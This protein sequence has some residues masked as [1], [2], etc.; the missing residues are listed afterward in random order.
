MKKLC[1]AS[2]RIAL[3]VVLVCS[4]CLN[5]VITSAGVVDNTG[6][7][8][9][10]SLIGQPTDNS[11]DTLFGL[12]YRILSKLS[13]L[14][15][16][17]TQDQI[18]QLSAKVDDIDFSVQQSV[19]AV[20]CYQLTYD[21]ASSCDFLTCYLTYADKDGISHTITGGTGSVY[22]K[23]GS[24]ISYYCYA[25]NVYSSCCYVGSTYYNGSH[26]YPKYGNTSFSSGSIGATSDKRIVMQAS[27]SETHVVHC[28]DDVYLNCSVSIT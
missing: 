28:G 24:V 7:S 1:E 12:L 11:S 25:G 4:L 3:V 5:P 2:P 15:T 10:M 16:L 13:K 21:V 14:D 26:N 8:A 18:T 6:S 17:A 23:R 19:A 20:T 22:V 9:A 27:K